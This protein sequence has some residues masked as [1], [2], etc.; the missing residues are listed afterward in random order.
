MKHHHNGSAAVLE[1]LAEEPTELLVQAATL[2]YTQLRLLA[3]C[4]AG[5]G[6]DSGATFAPAGADL[7]W[8]QNDQPVPP[9]TVLLP[10][11]NKGKCP[12]IAQVTLA[13]IWTSP[14]GFSISGE[15][16][17]VNE[18]A[19]ALFWSDSAVQKF[20]VPYVASCNGA[21]AGA[22]LTQ[23]QGAWNDSPTDSVGMFALMHCT[24]RHDVSLSLSSLFAFVAATTADP[25]VGLGVLPL[26]EYTSTKAAP[27]TDESLTALV[28]PA[29]PLEPFPD[30]HVLRAMAEWA[31][32]LTQG[33]RYFT[34]TPGMTKVA[35]PTDYLPQ[36][37]E[38]Q[39]MIPAYTSTSPGT[40]PTPAS[41]VI[42]PAGGDIYQLKDVA[43]AVFWTTGSIQQFLLPYY[44]S[45][46]GMKAPQELQAIVDCWMHN[47]P[48]HPESYSRSAIGAAGIPDDMEVFAL[49]HLPYSAWM[50]EEE[51][52][53]A[54][55]FTL[56]ADD[57]NL[58][59]AYHVDGE[60]WMDQ[61]SAMRR[62][63]VLHWHRGRTHL[64]PLADFR[65]L[66]RHYA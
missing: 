54:F 37:E 20:V 43:D 8:L 12:P 2:G 50:T 60:D 26:S 28:E 66:R 58:L 11:S 39:V 17:V 30:Y 52:H 31:A 62:V 65:V 5:L 16:N 55:Y 1:P 59:S 32:S 63:G 18:G 24:P 57:V 7:V 41:V 42:Q 48:H 19:D 34:V 40:R 53:T 47:Q 49:V 51:L 10:A 21:N 56:H 29:V 45:V 13:G 46:R 15:V 9:G 33:A 61:L 23:L 36:I 6:N 27:Y 44:A 35:A 38:G 22:A 64:L 3:E 25:A 4:A 14:T